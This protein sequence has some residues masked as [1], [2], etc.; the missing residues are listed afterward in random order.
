M[1]KWLLLYVLLGCAILASVGLSM[2]SYLNY[3]DNTDVGNVS[4]VKHLTNVTNEIVSLN[5]TEIMND[6]IPLNETKPSKPTS[7]ER[8]YHNKVND[9]RARRNLS[10]INYN[11]SLSIV[12]AE[13]SRLYSEDEY[14]YLDVKSP[15]FEDGTMYN[16]GFVPYG[17]VRGCGYVHGH[18]SIADCILVMFMSDHY[19]PYI[20]ADEIPNQ[21]K[22]NILNDCLVSHGVGIYEAYGVVGVGISHT[23]IGYERSKG[24]YVVQLFHYD[25][26]YC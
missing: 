13:F 18:K 10:L 1:N 4:D 3:R 22:E 2:H 8:H 16:A 15:F 19:S 25:R 11:D 26:S 6:T 7:I 23:H 21:D 20:Y 17:D 12:A 14:F 24:V 9:A 5:K